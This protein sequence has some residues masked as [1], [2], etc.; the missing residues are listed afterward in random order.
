MT[1]ELLI[2]R[3][4]KSAWDTDAPSDFERPLAKRGKRHA[5]RMGKWMQQCDLIPDS[6]VCSPA[7]RA[8][9]TADRVLR[10]LGLTAQDIRWEPRIY[11]AERQDLLQV[12]AACPGSATRVLLVGHNPGLDALLTYL[13]G[14]AVRPRADGKLMVTAA[15]AQLRMPDDWSQLTPGCGELLALTRPREVT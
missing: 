13:G 14:P 12:L 11:D 3:H 1:R 8:A 9:K 6:T 5:T 10:E 7:K 15:L 4:A 2:L